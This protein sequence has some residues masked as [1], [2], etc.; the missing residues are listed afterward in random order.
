[1]FVDQMHLPLRATKAFRWKLALADGEYDE[2]FK[3]RDNRLVL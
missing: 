1:M 2:I 3:M